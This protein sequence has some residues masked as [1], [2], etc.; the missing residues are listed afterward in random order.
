MGARYQVGTECGVESSIAHETSIL[1]AGIDFHLVPEP[2]LSFYVYHLEIFIQ[3]ESIPWRNHFKPRNQ[4]LR[5][6]NRYHAVTINF[7]EYHLSICSAE[8][9]STHRVAMTIF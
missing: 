2:S 5:S 1:E 8:P 3:E 6:K 9:Q 4:C 7:L